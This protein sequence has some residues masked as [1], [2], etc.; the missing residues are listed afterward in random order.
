MLEVEPTGQY[1]RTRHTAARSGR[2]GRGHIVS[3]PTWRY[4]VNY[5]IIIINYALITVTLNI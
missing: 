5:I 4:L 2:K 1:G 3:Q